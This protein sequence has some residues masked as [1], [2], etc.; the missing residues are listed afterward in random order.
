[1]SE[2]WLI[3]NF[4]GNFFPVIRLLIKFLPLKVDMRPDIVKNIL[5]NGVFSLCYLASTMREQFSRVVSMDKCYLIFSKFEY[6][7]NKIDLEIICDSVSQLILATN[8]SYG[9]VLIFG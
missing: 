7:V 9:L 1:M 6:Y 4:S 8:F 2:S 5:F 3:R